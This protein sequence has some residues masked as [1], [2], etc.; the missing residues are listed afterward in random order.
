MDK[1][2][3]RQIIILDLGWGN[4]NA[5][6][7]FLL[8]LGQTVKVQNLE[9]YLNSLESNNYIFIPGIGRAKEISKIDT[10]FFSKI[11]ERFSNEKC[12]F[13]ICLGMQFLCN[14]LY[15]ANVK[16]LNLFNLDVTK[17]ICGDFEK[18]NIGY[19]SLENETKSPRLFYFC[20]SYGVLINHNESSALEIVSYRNKIPSEFK[21]AAIIKKGNLVGLQFH[22]EKSGIEGLSLIRSLMNE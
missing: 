14:N 2:S 7:Y 5:L 21:Y 16:G 15:E 12:I 22:P 6:R 18:A 1:C 9:T 20:H 4:I 8:K 3:E 19:R 17:V 10:Y 13:G 11:K